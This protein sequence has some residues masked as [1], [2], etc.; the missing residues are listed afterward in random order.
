ILNEL[1]DTPLLPLN[2]PFYIESPWNT[3]AKHLFRLPLGQD[4]VIKVNSTESGGFDWDLWRVFDDN[5]YR[6]IDV[7]DSSTFHN[8]QPIYLPAGNYL[9][10]ATSGGVGYWGIYE[11]NAGPIVDGTGG[12][13]VGN[14]GLI[15]VRVPVSTMSFYNANFSLMTHDN[16]T[17]TADYDIMNTY[18]SIVR[19]WSGSLANIQSGTGWVG[20]PLN[21]TAMQLGVPTSYARFCDGDG[22]IIISPYSVQ[23]N[24]AGL[25]NY[26]GEYTVDYNVVFEE[27]SADLFNGTG[28]LDVTTSG[29]WH[30]FTLGDPADSTEIYRLTVTSARGTWINVSYYT[31][32]VNSFNEVYIFMEDEGCTTKLDLSDLGATMSGTVVAATFQVGTISEEITII[33]HLER[34]QVAEGSLDV[35]VEQLTTNTYQYPPEIM[36]VGPGAGAV[37]GDYSALVLVGGVG[38]L[39]VVVVVVLFVARK[40]GLLTR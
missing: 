16:V 30:N 11:F 25:T 5:V 32:D 3:E 23:N 31:T 10:E 2:Q 6:R 13:A 1:P 8:A 14:G 38:G 37:A 20:N 33:F 18:G 17:V 21:W 12:V 28:T 34:D 27:N 40:R 9:L 19:G 22:I 4:S 26:Y 24:T 29:G 39:A 15:G 35:F 7:A 36:Y